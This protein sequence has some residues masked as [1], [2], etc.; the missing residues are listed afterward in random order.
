LSFG[1]DVVFGRGL[2]WGACGLEGFCRW[3]GRVVC[4]KYRGGSRSVAGGQFVNGYA[5]VSF[6][7]RAEECEGGGVARAGRPVWKWGVKVGQQLGFRGEYRNTVFDALDASE[8][9]DGVEGGATVGV[10]GD[11]S[12]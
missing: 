7:G 12:M 4:V 2:F 11:G 6:A 5:D 10:G 8:G 1:L 3:R 9:A